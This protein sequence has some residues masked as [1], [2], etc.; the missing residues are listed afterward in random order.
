[1]RRGRGGTLR[2]A[3][4]A[5]SPA[6]ARVGGDRTG[7]RPSSARVARGVFVVSCVVSATA[8]ASGCEPVEGRPLSNA[9]VNRC[10]GTVTCDGYGDRRAQCTSDRCVI[11]TNAI[12]LFV[13]HVVVHVPDT[14]YDAPGRTFVIP[15]SALI[16]SS[17]TGTRR[18]CLPPCIE[19]PALVRVEGSYLVTT[20]TAT[21]VGYP[22]PL[23]EGASLPV[24]VSF[25]QLLPGPPAVGAREI[26]LPISTL[27]TSS[28]WVTLP[29][30]SEPA[31]VYANAVSVGS[32]QRSVFPEP[33]FDEYF[34]PV[35]TTMDVDTALVDD[36]LVG[37]ALTPLDVP[38]GDLRRITISRGEG[39]DGFSVWL[40][41][42]SSGERIS[43]RRALSGTTAVARLDTI[44]QSEGPSGA[45]RPGVDVVVAPPA[46]WLAVPTFRSRLFPIGADLGRAEYPAL[47]PPVTLA[48]AVAV[49]VGGG[50]N[51][52]A[53]R[54]HL[55][56][57]R[58][59]LADGADRDFLRYEA[60][61]TTDAS[62]RFS[63]VVPPGLY[64]VTVEPAE[65]TGFAKG[66]QPE[67][68][69]TRPRADVRFQPQARSAVVGRALLSDGRPLAGAAVFANPSATQPDGAVVPRPG[70]GRVRDD[71][72]F[73]LE[74]DPGRYDVVVEP[75]AGSGFPRAVATREVGEVRL[76]PAD[77][78]DLIAP[79]P[80]VVR[81]TFRAPAFNPSV[82]GNVIVRAVVRVFAQRAGDLTAP[83]VEVARSMTDARGECEILLAQEAP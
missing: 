44:G 10:G 56:S 75:E 34:P 82:P 81:L 53:S 6:P 21:D 76:E 36:V 52:V 25:T 70:R 8:L 67:I 5:G 64:E 24:R 78:G 4:S 77:L 26:G 18:P 1:M 72:A 45:L 51:G 27:V 30:S 68:D 11:G 29:S 35:S 71:G 12:P 58:V 83:L 17:T 39:L 46:T 16:Q 41:D 48:G 47:P 55:K 57:T 7:A 22:Q 74:L 2:A 43:S 20:Q 15:R 14:S 54:I 28:R 33:P 79:P 37:G 31:I 40:A 32:F 69:V 59:R 73:R 49:P 23:P 13:S 60:T 80:T 38:S 61:L 19:L 63:T 66:V 42:S 65:G 9:P 50:F 62:G 3:S